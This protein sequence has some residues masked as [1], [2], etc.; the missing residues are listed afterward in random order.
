M[1][2]GRHRLNND[3]LE[4]SNFFSVV[5][6]ENTLNLPTLVLHLLPIEIRRS[7]W[8]HRLPEK[9]NFDVN[10]FSVVNQAKPRNLPSALSSS[11]APLW[12]PFA[13]NQATVVTSY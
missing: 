1:H 9:I 2:D 13:S 10:L 8:N 7:H 4:R 12:H 3:Q 11:D 6:H 5:S